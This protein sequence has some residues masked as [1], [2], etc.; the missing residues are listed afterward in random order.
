MQ[1]YTHTH[2]T[3]VLV[4]YICVYIYVYIYIYLQSISKLYP[5]S[6]SQRRYIDHKQMHS[7]TASFLSVLS[8]T[9]DSPVIDLY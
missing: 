6:Y 7:F 3:F 9:A 4:L 8:E 1:I 5:V 2:T